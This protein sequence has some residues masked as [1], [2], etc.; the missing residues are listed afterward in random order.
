MVVMRPHLL[1][2]EIAAVIQ[3]SERRAGQ[4]IDP[5]IEKM[6]RLYLAYPEQTLRL[7]MDRAQEMRASQTT[8]C[9]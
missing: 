7:I 2:K 3:V 9:R 5:A 8:I 6:A 1:L 4:A